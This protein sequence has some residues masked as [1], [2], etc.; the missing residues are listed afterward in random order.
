M[1]LSPATDM[2]PRPACLQGLLPTS[3]PH[4]DLSNGTVCHTLALILRTLQTPQVNCQRNS[5]LTK[6]VSPPLFNRLRLKWV[7]TLRPESCGPSGPSPSPF[8]TKQFQAG[9]RL[10]GRGLWRPLPGLSAVKTHPIQ[11]LMGPSVPELRELGKQSPSTSRGLQ[12]V[13]KLP[14]THAV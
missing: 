10:L 5:F 1:A 11:G 4:K 9:G 14:S 13:R 3:L 12:A 6:A 2:H 7:Y 8:Y